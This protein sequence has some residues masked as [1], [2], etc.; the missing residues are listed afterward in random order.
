MI[1]FYEI[2]HFDFWEALT[3]MW[4]MSVLQP[5][6][7][8]KTCRTDNN[9]VLSVR[10]SDYIFREFS[11]YVFKLLKYPLDWQCFSLSGHSD[12]QYLKSFRHVCFKYMTI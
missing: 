1:V 4:K 6:T 9:L 5:E 3:V 10:I 11:R 2:R 8:K 7:D 12:W